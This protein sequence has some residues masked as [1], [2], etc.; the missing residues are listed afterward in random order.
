[1]LNYALLNVQLTGAMDDILDKYEGQEKVF[2]R[3][4]R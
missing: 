3:V 2:K 1:M 4:T